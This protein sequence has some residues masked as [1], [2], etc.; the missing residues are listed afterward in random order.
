MKLLNRKGN[1]TTLRKIANDEKT[2]ILGVV[3]TVRGLLQEH[4]FDYCEDNPNRWACVRADYEAFFGDSRD[5]AIAAA[6]IR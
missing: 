3:G 2:K 4:V 6:G 1:E 5:E